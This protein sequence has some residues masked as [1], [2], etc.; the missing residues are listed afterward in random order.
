VNDHLEEAMMKYKLVIILAI[1][2]L[3]LFIFTPTLAVIWGQPDGDSHPYVGLA[4]F[5]VD[6]IPSHRCSGTLLNETVFLTAGHCTHGTSGAR[7][8]FENP[9]TDPNYPFSGGTV[10]DGKPYT[11]GDFDNFADFP[12]T[13]DVGVV[14]L[15]EPVI[16]FEYGSLPN[17][18]QVNELRPPTGP[19]G[20]VTIVGYGFQGTVPDPN[21]P[22]AILERYFGN[23]MVKELNSA[24]TGEYNI[25]LTSDPGK[26]QG[27]DGFGGAC[28]GDSGG[29]AFF[30]NSNIIAGV[31]SYVLNQHCVGAGFYFRVDTDDA[32][33]FLKDHIDLP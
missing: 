16:M 13:H 25:H 4:V 10:V 5:D 3:L 21:Q 9:V 11:H 6:G 26:R 7:V 32:R 29:P 30:Y 18:G 33:N 8:W 23:P 15:D 17:E 22:E 19:P 28:F 27:G 14:I 1:F 31:G 20:Q 12:N 24:I 2:I